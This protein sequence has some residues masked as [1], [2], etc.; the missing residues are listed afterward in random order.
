VGRGSQHFLRHRRDALRIFLYAPR[1]EKVRRLI[2]R[3][4]S[5][6][7][8]IELVDTVDRER[9][10]FIAKYFKVEWPSRSIYHAMINTEVGDENVVQMI[11]ALMKTMD[12]K[13]AARV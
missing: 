8:A 2:S 12:S 13:L 4:K 9:S 10:D 5:E 3:G 1:E 7:E 11:E 6:N